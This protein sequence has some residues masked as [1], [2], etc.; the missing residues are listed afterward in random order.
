MTTVEEIVDYLEKLDETKQKEVLDWVKE[1]SQPQGVNGESL[2]WLVG[3]IS[4]EDITLMEEAI[5]DFEK[6]DLNEW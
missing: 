6:I 1:L 4:P 2:L 5:A 3:S